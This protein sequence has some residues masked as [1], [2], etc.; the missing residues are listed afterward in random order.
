MSMFMQS[1]HIHIHHSTSTCV[2]H[3]T[4]LPAGII[5]SS[6]SGFFFFF[7]N[8]KYCFILAEVFPLF[9]Y[10]CTITSGSFVPD[11][12]VLVN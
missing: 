2:H 10:L 5:K 9:H 11:K 1:T 3:L 6:R 8:V 7:E 4:S 12:S